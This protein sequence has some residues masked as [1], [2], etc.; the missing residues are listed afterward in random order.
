[1]KTLSK[2]PP[3]LE[4]PWLGRYL[5]QNTSILGLSQISLSLISSHI[6]LQEMHSPFTMP[7]FIDAVDSTSTA[8]E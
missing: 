8:E 2:E 1:M 4:P 7:Y 6:A 5:S 3:E